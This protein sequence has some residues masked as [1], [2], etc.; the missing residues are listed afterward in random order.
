M[1]EESS[2]E[3][4]EKQIFME[5]VSKLLS[6]PNE[7]NLGAVKR[8]AKELLAK[9]EK[10]NSRFVILVLAKVFFTLLPSYNIHITGYKYN[11]NAKSTNYEYQLILE[12]RSYLKLVTRSK[13]DE[14]Y[15]AAA[16]LLPQTILFNRSSKLVGKVIKG[17]AIKG[18]IGKKCIMTLR[19]IF[20]C[21]KGNRIIR[22]LEVFNQLNIN[23]VSI[24]AIKALLCINSSVLTKPERVEK[25]DKNS[26]RKLTVDEKAIKKE[27][28]LHSL[29][30]EIRSWKGINERLLRIYLLV[31][32]EKKIDK[33]W[34]VIPE[35]QRIRV[36]GNLHEGILSMLTEKIQELK[37][38]LTPA[39]V[40][41]LA[42]CYSTL[43]KV[44][45][46]K[47]EFSF[48]QDEFKNLPIDLL[49]DVDDKD[50]KS[51][52]S[53][54]K[55]IEKHQGDPELVK[56]IIK[57]GMYRIDSDLPEIVRY[58]LPAEGPKALATFTKNGFWELSLLRRRKIE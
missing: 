43:Y 12:W 22:I 11:P 29:P 54:L 15:E 16:I 24:S 26:M 2:K 57:R 40:P 18:R 39:R 49:L 36:P 17:T 56:L 37:K 25:L 33:Y 50:M 34:F 32:M 28:E 6:T 5:S 3:R 46:E 10:G 45:G 51:V 13:T 8:T 55:N 38:T 58:L 31:L 30:E 4:T 48:H 23:K 27:A 52:Y 41:I 44:F 20:K 9:K 42:H 35:I 47:L 19:K 14:S 21:D 7:K 1:E 53:S